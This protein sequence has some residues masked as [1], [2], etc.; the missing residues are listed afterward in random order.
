MFMFSLCGNAN[1]QL[2]QVFIDLLYNMG[3]III[4]YI[5]YFVI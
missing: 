3:Y 4:I 5:R 2:Y 1:S